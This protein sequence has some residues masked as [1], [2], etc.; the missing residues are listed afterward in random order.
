[1]LL[2]FR[3]LKP[4]NLPLEQRTFF[5]GNI[6]RSTSIDELPQLINVIKGDMSLIGPRPLPVEYY[7][8]FSDTQKQRHEVK[9]GITGLAQINGRSQ[10]S[11]S[12]KFEYDLYYVQNISFLLDLKIAIK[13]IL[14]VLSFKKD[15]SLKEEKFLGND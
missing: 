8:L 13:T 5:M 2:K 15:R 10:I 9:P 11:W 14:L 12:K 1:V 3:S 4:A 6:L 7:D